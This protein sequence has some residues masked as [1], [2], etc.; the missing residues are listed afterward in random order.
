MN[1]FVLFPVDTVQCYVLVL[2]SPYRLRHL[3]IAR[4]VFVV[5]LLF[6]EINLKQFLTIKEC[7][8][9]SGFCHSGCCFFSHCSWIMTSQ[10]IMR[11]TYTKRIKPR[12]LSTYSFSLPPPMSTGAGMGHSRPGAI[13]E[14][15][16]GA[17]LPQCP[18]SGLCV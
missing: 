5:V 15:H 11:T 17:L 7:K 8:R 9:M 3:T 1:S 13:S 14:I 12:N 4:F 6:T 10:D 18:R 16:G 2:V